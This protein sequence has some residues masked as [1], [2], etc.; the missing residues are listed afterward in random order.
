YSGILYLG[1]LHIG[2]A[3]R[4][5]ISYHTFNYFNTC[6][7]NPG[8]RWWGFVLFLNDNSKDFPKKSKELSKHHKAHFALIR[9]GKALLVI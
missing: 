4:G 9:A 6:T 5:C 2:K 7:D 1:N 8:K 3:I